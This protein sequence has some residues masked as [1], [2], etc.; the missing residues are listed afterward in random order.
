[1]WGRGGRR[2]PLPRLQLPDGGKR[3]IRLPSQAGAKEVVSQAAVLAPR[4]KEEE[5]EKWGRGIGQGEKKKRKGKR[6]KW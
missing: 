3:G 4:K 6:W 1:M 5:E 2:G